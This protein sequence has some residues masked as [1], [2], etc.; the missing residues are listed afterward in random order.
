MDQIT[1]NIYLGDI[2]AANINNLKKENINKVLSVTDSRAP[3]YRKDDKINQKNPLNIYYYRLSIISF[4]KSSISSLYS[5]F[6]N[7]PSF[8]LFNLSISLSIFEFDGG[9]KCNVL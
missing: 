9:G 4:I 6:F 7:F 3:H 1:D 5:S 2:D 8:F